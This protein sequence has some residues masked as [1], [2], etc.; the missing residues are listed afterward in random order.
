MN[1]IARLRS[2]GNILARR[3]PGMLAAATALFESLLETADRAIAT[4]RMPTA[5]AALTAEQVLEAALARGVP[6]FA[7][8]VG[9]R[10][11][12]LASL[13]L[14]LT[15]PEIRGALVELH[16][17]GELRL[18]SIGDLDGARADLTAR[19]L[20]IDLVDESAISDGDMTL[21]AVVVA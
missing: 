3:A 18:A 16:G 13:G 19:G 7:G 6:A 21:H 15:V 2:I 11:I 8:A 1:R 9:D 17:R 12:L 10:L 20:S 14:D 5:P 4:G